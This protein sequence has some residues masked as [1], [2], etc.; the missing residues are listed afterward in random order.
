MHFR[1]TY[2]RGGPVL[3][4]ALE[5]VDTAL[6]EDQRE[7]GPECWSTLFWVARGRLS[8]SLGR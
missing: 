4:T 8:I 1:G 7:A 6:W 2:G 5:G 3:M